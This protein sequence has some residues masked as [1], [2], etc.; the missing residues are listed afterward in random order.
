MMH[1]HLELGIAPDWRRLAQRAGQSFLSLRLGVRLL[2]ALATEGH[3]ILHLTSANEV[4]CKRPLPFWLEVTV[5]LALATET[6]GT[7][8]SSCSNHLLVA[9]L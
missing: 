3:K 2:L 6:Y 4:T 5:R 9:V 8:I 7:A 1:P